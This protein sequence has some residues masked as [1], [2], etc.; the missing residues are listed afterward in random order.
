[1]TAIEAS[2]FKLADN[3]AVPALSPCSSASAGCQASW[4]YYLRT[5]GASDRSRP[6]PGNI[7]ISAQEIAQ[8]ILS[9]N[10]RNPH[11]FGAV[12][13][14]VMPHPHWPSGSQNR[15]LPDP[16]GLVR[17]VWLGIRSALRQPCRRIWLGTAAAIQSHTWHLASTQQLRV[18]CQRGSQRFDC[19][20]DLSSSLLA[21]IQ[22]TRLAGRL[23]PV[24]AQAEPNYNHLLEDLQDRPF[25]RGELVFAGLESSG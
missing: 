17:L 7:S 20:H 14:L 19:H 3:L 24:E 11:H 23:T 4:C 5:K 22:C 2:R 9:T 6:W 25:G 21:R 12:T 16:S 1:M 10:T 8:L 13:H 18:R 15:D